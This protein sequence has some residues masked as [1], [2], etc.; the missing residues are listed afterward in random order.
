MKGSK[1]TLSETNTGMGDY[2]FLPVMHLSNSVLC[3]K[4]AHYALK[5]A[6]IFTFKIFGA[7]IIYITRVPEIYQEGYY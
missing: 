3:L 2:A 7:Q 1:R 5:Y 4:F 6:R